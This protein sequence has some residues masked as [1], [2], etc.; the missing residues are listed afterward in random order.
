LKVKIYQL[1]GDISKG[2]Q[3]NVELVDEFGIQ[4]DNK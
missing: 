2:E 1:N 4:K 3:R